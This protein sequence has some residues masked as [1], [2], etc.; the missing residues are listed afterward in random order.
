MMTSL[1]TTLIAGATDPIGLALARHY[2]A[3][4]D[5]LVLIGQRPIAELDP[6][7]FTPERYCQVDPARPDWLEPVVQFVRAQRIERIE[8]VI[9]HGTPGYY[10][11]ADR[12]PAAS[13][14]GLVNTNLRAPIALTHAL[15]PYVWRAGG[16]LVFVCPLGSALPLGRLAVYAAT[17]AALCGFARSLRA[18]LGDTPTVQVLRVGATSVAP[19]AS[20]AIF[21]PSTWLPRP[22]PDRVAAQL[23]AAVDR[24]VPEDTIGQLNRLLLFAARSCGGLID[25]VVR[26]GR[27]PSLP[28]GIARQRHY[29]ITGAADGIGKALARQAAA[30][31]HAV[32]GIDVDRQR[33]KLASAELAGL[34]GPI[35]FICADLA[36]ESGVEHALGQLESGP[37]IDVLV[38]AASVKALGRFAGT[39]LACQQ[40][41]LDVNLV[42]AQFL[43]AGVLRRGLIGSGG[44]LAFVASLACFTGYPGAA[45]Y[46]ASKSGLAAYAR[47]LGAALA[48][49]GIHVLTI[50]PG[51]DA[52]RR[53]PAH[54][55]LRAVEAR[56]HTLIPGARTRLLALLGRCLPRV[57]EA[58]LRQQT[59]KRH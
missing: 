24:R 52:R 38:H 44:T 33:V 2:A 22:A 10:G 3:R 23:A 42:A 46:A 18:E 35:A 36:R 50:F 25:W 17:Q 34:G 57:A 39:D 27:R 26:R 28:R 37:A 40:A 51:I 56:R 4:G 13:I 43:T 14:A 1:P 53:A 16:S 12:Q 41:V 49:R 9:Q 11:P 30:A 15:L 20:R 32:T 8:R 55:I 54:A 59:L 31:G 45:V 6:S 48:P 47:C 7:L 5:R 19:P 58:L 29:V 21:E